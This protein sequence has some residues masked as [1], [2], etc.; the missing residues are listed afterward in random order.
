MSSWI[1]PRI[2]WAHFSLVYSVIRPI[3]ATHGRHAFARGLWALFCLEIVR[4]GEA[5]AQQVC[6][7]S[8]P[9]TRFTHGKLSPYVHAAEFD[10]CQA[11][12]AVLEGSIYI[13]PQESWVFILFEHAPSRG[14]IKWSDAYDGD[15]QPSSTLQQIHATDSCNRFMQQIHA[16]DSCNRF[17]QQIHAPLFNRFML[18]WQEKVLVLCARRVCAGRQLFERSWGDA[19]VTLGWRWD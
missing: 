16:T 1:F 13:S 9:T 5:N 19:G 6:T 18:V 4:A 8:L 10:A 17:M 2:D 12:S 11:G 14:G 3:S 7:R 15:H